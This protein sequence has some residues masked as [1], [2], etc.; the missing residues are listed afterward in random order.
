[1][2]L[3][4]VLV[5]CQYFLSSYASFA[6]TFLWYFRFLGRLAE[7]QVDGTRKYANLYKGLARH[8]LH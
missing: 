3:K 1:M 5:W 2:I 7:L 8:W 4:S 6:I